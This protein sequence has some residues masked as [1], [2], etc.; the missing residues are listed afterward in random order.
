MCVHIIYFRKHDGILFGIRE[1]IH[2]VK[3]KQ[4]SGVLIESMVNPRIIVQPLLEACNEEN[5]PFLC[6]QN[7]R[8]TSQQ[9]FGI[10]ASALGVKSN[11]LIDISNQII[12][13]AKCYTVSQDKPITNE[14]KDDEMVTIHDTEKAIPISNSQ[15]NDAKICPYLYRT[16]KTRIFVPSGAT[17]SAKTIKNFRGQNY[18]EFSDK[19]T[20][21]K[22]TEGVYMKMMLKRVSSNP[23][24]KSGKTKIG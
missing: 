13:I 12:D 14:I 5:I 6:V 23:N 10:P 7:L 9:Y 1:C 24:R 11:H 17:E 2:A 19:L 20:E 15:N 16:G 21:K 3:V 22:G 8:E 18:I 4:C